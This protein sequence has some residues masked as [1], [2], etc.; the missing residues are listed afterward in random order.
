MYTKSGIDK[1]LVRLYKNKNHKFYICTKMVSQYLYV[2]L[3]TPLKCIQK[4]YE[5]YPVALLDLNDSGRSQG[6]LIIR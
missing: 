2:I 1:D 5:I 4:L 3:C 6:T